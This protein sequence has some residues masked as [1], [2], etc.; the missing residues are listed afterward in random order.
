MVLPVHS[1]KYAIGIVCSRQIKRYQKHENRTSVTYSKL[2]QFYLIT[3]VKVKRQGHFSG[4]F[5]V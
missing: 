4:L 5:C 2:I 3:L 1:V